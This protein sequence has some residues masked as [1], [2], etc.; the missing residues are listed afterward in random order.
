MAD[1]PQGYVPRHST[2]GPLSAPPSKAARTRPNKVVVIVAA[3]LAGAVVVAI[4]AWLAMQSDDDT[5]AT[6]EGF[7]QSADSYFA[8]STSLPGDPAGVREL[9]DRR[10][11]AAALMARQ[12]PDEIRAT[13]GAY[14]ADVKGARGAFERRGYSPRIVEEAL[15]GTLTPPEDTGAVLRIMGYSYSGDAAGDRAA[16]VVA[17]RDR[18]CRGEAG[19]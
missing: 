13:A 2:D 4:G 18:H 8:A 12:A 16:Q 19:Q 11:E 5:G 17:Y 6:L 9:V 14:A 7:C 15:S 3:V 1:A 10:V